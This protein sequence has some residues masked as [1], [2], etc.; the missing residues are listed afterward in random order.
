MGDRND[1]QSNRRHTSIH[2]K[3]QSPI[4]VFSLHVHLPNI[5]PM[6]TLPKLLGRKFHTNQFSNMHD[7]ILNQNRKHLPNTLRPIRTNNP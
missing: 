7:N 6:E 1:I 3:H 2:D 5:Q 4:K